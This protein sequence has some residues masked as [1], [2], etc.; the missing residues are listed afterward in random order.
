MHFSNKFKCSLI[1]NKFMFKMS[2]NSVLVKSIKK[3][4]FSFNLS[5]KFGFKSHERL[6]KIYTK[7]HI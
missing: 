1:N 5:T 7:I 2:L 3:C 6:N 4:N